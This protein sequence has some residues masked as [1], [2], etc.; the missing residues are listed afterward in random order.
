MRAY[1]V[2]RAD[3]GCCPGHDKYPSGRYNCTHASARRRAQ[4]GRKKAARRWGKGCMTMPMADDRI[5]FTGT[6]DEAIEYLRV[7]WTRHNADHGVDAQSDVDDE[8]PCEGCGFANGDCTTSGG[9]PIGDY[10][11][12]D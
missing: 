9:C 10:S 5:V 4:R 12:S 3:A 7:A 1:G 8:N 2:R 6:V 11:E